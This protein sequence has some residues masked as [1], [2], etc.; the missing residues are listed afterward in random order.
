M[1]SCNIVTVVDGMV[2]SIETFTQGELND[3][4][5]IEKQ[6]LLQLERRTGST[7]FEQL[8]DTEKETFCEDGYAEFEHAAGIGSVQIFWEIS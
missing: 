8:S 2:E 4:P 7:K 3:T 1:D 5:N 6:F